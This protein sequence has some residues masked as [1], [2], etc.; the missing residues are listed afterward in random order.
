[1]K[2][3]PRQVTTF[4]E[5][6]ALQALFDTFVATEDK[7][8]KSF[9]LQTLE[10]LAR[11]SKIAKYIVQYIDDLVQQLYTVF[12]HHADLRSDIMIFGMNIMKYLDN[13]EVDDFIMPMLNLDKFKDSSAIHL[14]S[15]I[16]SYH[17]LSDE[18]LEENI[19]MYDQLSKLLDV[20]EKL[21]HNVINIFTNICKNK[22]SRLT[23]IVGKGIWNSSCRTKLLEICFADVM[24]ISDLITDAG[25][26]ENTDKPNT[27][28]ILSLSIDCMSLLENISRQIR[29]DDNYKVEFTSHE[30]NLFQLAIHQNILWFPLDI[31]N[32]LAFCTNL[33]AMIS[34][35]HMLSLCE[36]Q[37]ECKLSKVTHIIFYHIIHTNSDILKFQAFASSRACQK[38]IKKILLKRKY[39]N[40][41]I[42]ILN[43]IQS[44]LQLTPISETYKKRI[45][46]QIIDILKKNKIETQLMK[47]GIDIEYPDEFKCPITQEI[48]ENPIVASDGI[49]YEKEAYLQYISH[50][51]RTSPL[52]RET[53]DTQICVS[54]KNLK[55]RIRDY[56]EDIYN[57]FQKKQ[58][59]C[60]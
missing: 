1:M 54:N 18:W 55:K 16:I 19:W 39:D 43:R 26:S 14:L 23:K 5:Y 15:K 27:F 4:I 57:K 46:E 29:Y 12:L 41:N 59:H 7:M 17:Q 30:V 38:T 48:M 32:N 40:K 44:F 36:Q 31:L 60:E 21:C 28:E 47:E 34:S 24:N 33:P 2:E 9:I 22:N 53:L 11:D 6:G 51:N 45:Q 13:F 37:T 10:E 3:N 25:E 52:T 35:E 50:G 58:I 42:D 56:S 49:S 20:N 8:E